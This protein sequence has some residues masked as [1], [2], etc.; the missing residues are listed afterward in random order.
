MYLELNSSID[1]VSIL[2]TPSYGVQIVPGKFRVFVVYAVSLLNTNQISVFLDK[3]PPTA[4]T[5][6]F[7]VDETADEIDGE[8]Q[9][10]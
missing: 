6:R 5:T 4:Q 3:N 9:R 1:G 7:A 2:G 8:S 10:L